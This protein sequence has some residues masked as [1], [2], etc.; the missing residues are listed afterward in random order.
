MSVSQSRAPFFDF[1]REGR[2]RRRRREGKVDSRVGRIYLGLTLL[3]GLSH[4]ILLWAVYGPRSRCKTIIKELE[5][6]YNRVSIIFLKCI[7]MSLRW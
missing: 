3:M 4:V 5:K 2:R 7:K 6:P 1:L